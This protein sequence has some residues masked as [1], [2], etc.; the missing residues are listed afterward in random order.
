MLPKIKLGATA[1]T[2][3]MPIRPGAPRPTK[4][5]SIP[6][7]GVLAPT[8]FTAAGSAPKQAPAG[9]RPQ[10]FG[11]THFTPFTPPPGGGKLPASPPATAARQARPPITVPPGMRATKFIPPTQASVFEAAAKAAPT[12]AAAARTPLPMTHVDPF[13]GMEFAVKKGAL[14]S[15]GMRF[16]KEIVDPRALP[17]D[18]DKYEHAIQ[19]TLD[20]NIS[21]RL[22]T[23]LRV[24][25][26][27]PRG[28]SSALQELIDSAGSIIESS[29]HTNTVGVP[30]LLKRKYTRG[31]LA[32]MGGD[33]AN[34]TI[35]WTARNPAVAALKAVPVPGISLVPVMAEKALDR[36][37]ANPQ[38]IRPSAG[39]NTTALGKDFRVLKSLK[40]HI[41]RHG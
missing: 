30:A 19:N 22:N 11:L 16:L 41:Q 23:A 3:K 35:T 4:P 36:V 29:G 40:D 33:L 37:S 2:G 14:I 1:P 26:K 9:L 32:T 15:K 38:L 39:M 13:S 34:K 21:R 25:R 5:L 27:A 7:A 31:Q 10:D 8:P 24:G 6:G 20:K 17:P 12:G 28:I 18:L